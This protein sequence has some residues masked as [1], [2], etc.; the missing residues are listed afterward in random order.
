MTS[1]VVTARGGFATALRAGVASLPGGWAVYAAP[2]DVTS[3]PALVI[4][5]GS[6]YREPTTFGGAS[7]KEQVNLVLHGFVRRDAGND[8]LDLMDEA[9][10][11]VKTV[12]GAMPSADWSGMT[13]EGAV[14]VNGIP[15]LGFTAD[16]S[17]LV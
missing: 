14:D 15:A 1:A 12:L 8:A 6:P 17:V 7:A 16:V 13:P 11:D 9:W 4:G 5:P 10:D 2:Q 3:V